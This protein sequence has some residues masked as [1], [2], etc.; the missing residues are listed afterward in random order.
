MIRAQDLHV[1]R[2]PLLLAITL[3]ALGATAVWL[4]H[5]QS[6]AAATQHERIRQQHNQA[7]QRL[8]QARTDEHAVRQTIDRYDAL[9][10]QGLIGPEHRLEWVETLDA[11]RRR[12][13]ID[14]ISYEI[15]PQ[16]RIEADTPSA[17]PWMESRMRLSLQVRHSE[18]LL[19]LLDDLRRV[20][21]AI[22]RTDSCRL[23]RRADQAGLDG[24]C[25]LRWL[26]LQ[27]EAPA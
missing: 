4:A 16:R 1:L 11:A 3:L 25:E 15:Q 20:S 6:T 22:V 19:R 12:H 2:W 13:G 5:A 17:L 27:P 9:V 10:R 14:T 24:E 21:T 23:T 7:N 8:L 26:T 18:V